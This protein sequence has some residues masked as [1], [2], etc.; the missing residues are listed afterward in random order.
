MQSI[1]Q[2][3]WD[4]NIWDY[5]TWDYTRSQVASMQETHT[6]PE[7]PEDFSSSSSTPRFNISKCSTGKSWGLHHSTEQQETEKCQA[8]EAYFPP[9]SPELEESLDPKDEG[10]TA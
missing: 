9:T 7:D 5:N 8:N 10:E 6:T 2:P 4:Y 1:C 3:Q